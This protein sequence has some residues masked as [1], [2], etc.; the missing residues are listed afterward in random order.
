MHKEK[1]IFSILSI[2][3]TISLIY[4]ILIFKNIENVFRLIIISILIIIDIVILVKIWKSKLT[5]TKGVFFCTYI[6][7]LMVAITNLKDIYGNLKSISASYSI[8]GS[9]IVK[10]KG[11]ELNNR[12]IGVLFDDME[13]L[14]VLSF[15]NLELV[16]ENSYL[17]ILNDLYEEKIYYAYLPSNYIQMFNMLEQYKSIE[18]DTE[19]IYTN[20]KKVKIE[21]NN[22]DII[23]NPFSILV[24]GVDSNSE[25]SFNGDAL[26]L[27]TFNPK[28]LKSTVLSIPRDTYTN[29]T[30][31]NN[32]RKNK[33]T[34]AA[35]YGEDCMISSIENLFDIKINYFVKI[36]FEGFV[37]LVDLLG[38]IEVDV[39]ISFCEQDSK[40]NFDNQIC[41]EKG[42][43]NLNGEE[44]LALARHRKTINDFI[45]ND[46]QKII[47]ESLVKKIS[48]DLSI[49]KLKGI[50]NIISKNIT[51]NM[52]I[53]NIMNLYNLVSKKDLLSKSQILKLEGEDA[54]IYDYDFIHNEGMDM[55]LY[56][57]VPNNDN[58]NYVSSIM[59]ENLYGKVNSAIKDRSVILLP[60][61]N[62]INEAKDFC[63]KH[64]IILDIE[65]KDSNSDGVVLSQNIPPNTDI[66]YISDLTIEVS[67]KKEKINCL[68]EEYKNSDKCIIPNFI[69]KDYDEFKTWLK[70]NNYSF[71]INT[72]TI[73]D[74]DNKGK[75]I[76]QSISGVY[77]VDLIGKK[78]EITYVEK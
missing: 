25:S 14:K 11:K 78:I 20:Y 9:S 50:L 45:R 73:K 72:N 13:H 5:F 58:I 54:Y 29:I 37:S 61:F 8:S 33:I 60:E 68:S 10:L 35:W 59:Q 64:N 63:N 48:N 46:N 43:K 55:L 52:S 4:Y 17:D 40:R 26:I 51:T 30:C 2:F 47:L 53:D 3:L 66:D 56:D 7:F 62:N 32:N 38:G 19:V 23:N 22:I 34:H 1:I 74:N 67:K 71:I 76:K 42:L 16:V 41:L 69:G 18:N 49:D 36:N 77:I 75:I 27:I 39:P 21:N 31:F 57:F 65:Y 12:K 44:A 28:T 6:L 70:Q 24:M 15:Y